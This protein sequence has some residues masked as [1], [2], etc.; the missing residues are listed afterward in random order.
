MRFRGYRQGQAGGACLISIVDAAG[1]ERVMG[2]P[3]INRSCESRHSPDG[4][5]FGYSGSGPTEL[6]RAM[7]I[8]AIPGDARVRHPRCYRHFRDAFISGIKRDEFELDF[9]VVRDWFEVWTQTP[10]GRE[11]EQDWMD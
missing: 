9:K 2:L 3:E 6:A 8:A 10:S 11:I 5:Q 4:F 1:D 7:L